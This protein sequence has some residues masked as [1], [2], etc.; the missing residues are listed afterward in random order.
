[1]LRDE[2]EVL[3]ELVDEVAGS[4][5]GE[6]ELARA[7]RAAAG[8]ARLVVPA[9]RRRRRRRAAP[10]VGAPGGRVAALPERGTVELDI[11]DGVRAVAEYGVLRFERLDAS[12]GRG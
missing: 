9:A 5:R 7:A 2:G 11:G 1:M 4:G 3:D 12:A 6:I 10:G 8:A